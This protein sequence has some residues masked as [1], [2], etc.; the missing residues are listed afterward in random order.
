MVEHEGECLKPIDCPYCLNQY[1][2]GE[3]WREENDICEERQCINGTIKYISHQCD[4]VNEPNCGVGMSIVDVSTEKG[5]LTIFIVFFSRE[6]N[7][8]YPCALK[9]AWA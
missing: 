1:K 3:T 9:L 8:F 2:D 7:Y 5:R 6:I 4:Q